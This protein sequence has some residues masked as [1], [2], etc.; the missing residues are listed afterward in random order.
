MLKMA[1]LTRN[2]TKIFKALVE[3]E[4][5]SVYCTKPCSIFIPA[6]WKNSPLARLEERFYVLSILMVK[7][8][9]DY[10]VLNVAGTIELGVTEYQ[11]TMID[12][13]DCLEFMYDVGKWLSRT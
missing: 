12:G 10:A 9:T 6:K 13:V 1:S 5:D 7:V 8:G 3:Q 2:P 11:T 4:D